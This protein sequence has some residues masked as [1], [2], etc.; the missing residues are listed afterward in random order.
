MGVWFWVVKWL[1]CLILVGFDDIGYDKEFWW[2]EFWILLD[3]VGFWKLDFWVGVWMNQLYGFQER[4]AADLV[5]ATP[6]TLQLRYFYIF[7]WS[8]KCFIKS[9]WTIRVAHNRTS[10]WIIILSYF[11]DL[12]L[13]TLINYSILQ[14]VTS[15]YSFF[16]K[17]QKVVDNYNKL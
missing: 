6:Y 5:F 4:Q 15:K 7:P 9:S 10:V 12:L 1:K 16:K 17:L 13:T 14:F 11:W 3:F 8:N 2:V